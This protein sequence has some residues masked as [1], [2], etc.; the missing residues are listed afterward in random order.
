MSAETNKG[1]VI[2]Q[3][4]DSNALGN[5]IKIILNTELDLEN[6]TAAFQIGSLRWTFDDITSKELEIVVT[7]EQSKQLAEGVEYAAL[8]V[9]DSAGRA[10]TIIR[11]VPVYVKTQVVDNE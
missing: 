2:T 10:I 11:D 1:I 6:F 8:K 3:G 5:T 4:D 9:F 7:K